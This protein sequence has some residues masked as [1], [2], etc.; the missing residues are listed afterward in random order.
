[1]P[2]AVFLTA[3]LLT[4]F[5]L[6]VALSLFLLWRARSAPG[7]PQL[8]GFV[9]IVGLYALGLVVPPRV[10]ELLLALAPLGSAVS[11]DF[12]IRLTGFGRRSLFFVH[13]LGLAAT[14]AQFLFG[15]GA[16]FETAEGLRGFRYEGAGLIG[17]AV[18]L[19]LAIYGNF[20]LF[21]AL[22]RSEGKRRREIA[23]VL[24]SALIG[25]S[26]VVSFAPPLFGKMIAPWSIVALPAYPATLVYGMLRYELMAAN[27]WARR[28]AAYAL[29]VLLAAAV[30]G[31]LAAAPLSLLA[32][33]MSFLS[34]WLVVAGAMALA[35]ALGEPIRH[36]ADRLVYL[37]AE[38][39][40]ERIA[41][42]RSELFRADAQA[43][44]LDIAQRHLSGA[45]RPQVEATFASQGREPA[46][47]C[48]RANDAWVV[49]LAGFEDS[50]PGARRIAVIYADLLA[51]ALD[52]LERRQMQAE[53]E[54]L[55]ELGMLAST[56]AHDLRNPLN[57]LNMAAASAPLELKQEIVEQTRRMNRL[58]TDLLDY[59]KPWR[60]EPDDVDLRAAFGTVETHIDEEAR[61]RA[62]PLRFAQAVDNLLA[63][64][65]AAGGRVRVFVENE[66]DATRIH[67]CDDGAG[68]PDDIRDKLFQP[69]VSR[70][71][72]GTGLGLAIV[73]KVM[74]AHGGSVSLTTRAGFSTC[75][76]MEF[77]K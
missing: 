18:A 20:L 5:F 22:R 48:A 36:A 25:L 33:S 41:D 52:E 42:W 60:I 12:V 50:P 27:V 73:A 74:A 57:I 44:L 26:T 24:S 3:S 49:R 75:V 21:V 30:S 40:A 23:I 13:A 34:L 63:N 7:A 2:P 55:A 38:I 43:D 35:F 17:V 9:A 4:T 68:V 31:L 14:L 71:A 64:A 58:V 76:T 11:A 61:L 56:I 29:I 15:A 70:A 37:D 66:S 28:A 59:A 8:A 1:M 16:F 39:S 47:R 69:F 19:G 62:D 45:M 67:I 6:S 10:G 46:L 54:R 32:P 51:Q 77:P 53:S 65:R 72:E